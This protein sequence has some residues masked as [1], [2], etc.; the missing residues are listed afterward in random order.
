MRLPFV[1]IAVCALLLSGCELDGFLFNEKP[2]DHYELPGNT[3]PDSLLELVTF[4]SGGNT[5][6]G[7]WVRSADPQRELTILYCKGNKHNMDEYWD[8]VLILHELGVNLFLYDYRGFGMSQGS[9][10]ERGMYEDGEAAWQ[11][12]QTR[13][14]VRADSLCL[15]GYSLGN[16]VSIH[17]TANVIT[18]LCLFA[19]AAFASA[20]SLTQSALAL[21]IPPLW[22]TEGSFDNVETIQSI[23]TPLRLFHGADDDFVRF[24]DNGKRVH[25][26]AP[27][28][29]SLVLVEGANHTD[30]PTVMGERHYRQAVQEWIDFSI[31]R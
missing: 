28:P 8:R 21:D 6:Y 26:A 29:K 25:E 11:L 14:G 23:T 10:T 27:E 19:E 12:L 5:L 16:I 1:T 3:I 30:I 17:L 22:L 24:R 7:Y 9:S 31:N 20:S 18:P 15:Y 2:V 4:D 13:Y